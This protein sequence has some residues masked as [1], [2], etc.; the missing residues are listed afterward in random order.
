MPS[1]ALNSP[2][3]P[4]LYPCL[5]T[6]QPE[7]GP[8]KFSLQESL[9]SP[10]A[11][12]FLSLSLREDYPTRSAAFAAAISANLE[13]MALMREVQ[14]EREQIVV[15]YHATSASAARSIR[16][17]GFR[18]GRK[19]LAGGAIYFATSEQHASR[20][21]NHGNDVVLKCQ[22]TLGRTLTLDKDGDP[23]MTLDEL[24]GMGYDSVKILRNG[25]EYVVYEPSRVRVLSPPP[26]TVATYPRSEPPPP[27][28]ATYTRSER[29]RKLAQLGWYGVSPN[30]PVANFFLAMLP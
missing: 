7:F 11:L 9:I 20:K 25:D 5:G 16:A 22:V 3:T 4:S 15:G 26:P 1:F 13:I 24:N 12:S 14:Q 28:V 23:T 19:G 27:T 18:C 10:V 30:D 21:S 2:H 6:L 8:N 17:N 29:D